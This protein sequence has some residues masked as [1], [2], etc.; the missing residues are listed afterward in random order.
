MP[1]EEGAQ[2]FQCAAAVRSVDA[3]LFFPG[4]RVQVEQLVAIV[5]VPDIFESAPFGHAPW[6]RLHPVARRAVKREQWPVL[7]RGIDGQEGCAAP[8]S[9]DLRDL[10]LDDQ[11]VFP[12]IVGTL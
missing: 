2:I 10:T 1:F 3:V 11:G 8:I 4:I 7:G 9:D 5:V 6:N 12:N